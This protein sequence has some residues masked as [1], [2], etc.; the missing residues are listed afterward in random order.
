MTGGSAD[1]PALRKR[2]PRLTDRVPLGRSGLLV[3]PICV[4]T[5]DDPAIVIDA[6]GA[7][8][9][10]FFLTADM[11]WPMYEGTRLGLAH[12][13][14]KRPEVRQRLVVAVTSYVSQPEF[15]RMPF[16]EVLG[17]VPGLE[18]V[19]VAIIGGSYPQDFFSRLV[20]YRAQ[21]P[22]DMRAVGATFHERRSA[23]TAVNHGLI[24]VGFVRYNSAHPGAEHDV[25][26]H[27]L[28]G[29]QARMFSFGSSAGFVPHERLLELGVPESRW[30]PRLVDHYRFALSSA[31]VDGVLCALGERAHV[32][33]LAAALE[34]G[35]LSDAERSYLMTLSSLDA[36]RV[37]LDR[38]AT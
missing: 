3:S 12:L 36:G 15:C 6:F 1:A 38:E 19:D 22:G 16:E 20:T 21:R 8:I 18:H 30:R 10:F 23:V 33:E 13:L 26:P 14:A 4:G 5:V 35:P 28:E 25:L 32:G 31:R 17:V 11:H 7:G 37:A 29:G 9:N 24:D 2:L 27:L 34:S